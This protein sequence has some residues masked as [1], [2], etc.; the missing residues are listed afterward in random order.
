MAEVERVALPPPSS[1]AAAMNGSGAPEMATTAE[2]SSAAVTN[3]SN[4]TGNGMRTVFFS[5]SLTL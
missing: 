1:N 5:N 3:T 2:F 4:S